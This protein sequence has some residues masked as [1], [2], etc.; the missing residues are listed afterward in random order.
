MEFETEA[1][2][3]APETFAS[4][5]AKE[6]TSADTG[7]ERVEGFR[8]PGDPASTAELLKFLDRPHG[9]HQAA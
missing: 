7:E 6:S 2:E 5:N 9:V 4:A 3:F 1:T 8:A